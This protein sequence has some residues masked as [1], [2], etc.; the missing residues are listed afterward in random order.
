MQ[1]PV[2]LIFFIDL[3]AG[4]YIINEKYDGMLKQEN[5][6]VDVWVLSFCWAILYWPWNYEIF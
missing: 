4:E 1:T 3:F 6:F 5:N 2:W